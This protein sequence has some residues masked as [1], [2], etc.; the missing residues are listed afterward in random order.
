MLLLLASKAHYLE[1][2]GKRLTTLPTPPPKQVK[3]SCILWQG[4]SPID[5]APIACIATGV[6]ATSKNRKTGA[7]VQT[8]IIRTDISP[9]E[10]AFTGADLSICGDCPHRY[11]KQSD[12]TNRRTCYVNVSQA[13]TSV[14]KTFQR[15]GYRLA[16]HA[17]RAAIKASKLRIGSYGDPALVPYSVWETIVPPRR[18]DRTG[19]THLW[20][21]PLVSINPRFSSILMASADTDAQAV[22]AQSKGWRTFQVVPIGTTP[23]NGF[24]CPSDPTLPTHLP[25]T[26]C[27]A[28]NGNPHGRAKSPY[29]TAHGISARYVGLNIL[30]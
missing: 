26:D 2:L 25:C 7:M 6:G 9:N 16:T 8:W 21:S 30:N 1:K 19:Y 24:Q 5:G 13:P 28:C 29:I 17:D 27:G 4:T 3:T 22:D 10:A 15:G 20:N 14:Y 12:G 18:K 11:G 23:V